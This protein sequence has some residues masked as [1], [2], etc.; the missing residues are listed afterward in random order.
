MTSAAH[1]EYIR[2]KNKSSLIRRWIATIVL[3]SDLESQ[4]MFSCLD[5]VITSGFDTSALTKDNK[6]D[7]PFVRAWLTKELKRCGTGHFDKSDVFAVNTQQIQKAMGL[8][9]VELEVFRFA[10]LLCCYRPLG[11]AAEVGSEGYT[12][13]DVCDLL[14]ELLRKPFDVIYS[15]LR[16]TGLLR[17]SGLVQPSGGGIGNQPLDRWLTIPVMLAREIFR[18]QDEDNL[19]INVFYKTGPK[20]TLKTPDFP[21]RSELSLLKKY[22][23]ASVK[24]G[25]VGANVL[26]WGPPGTGKTEMAR[27]AAQ[28]LRKRSLEISTIDGDNQTLSATD[29]LDC[30]RF[31]QAILARSSNAI[32]TFDEVE[33]V[34]CDGNYSQWGFRAA[35]KFSKSMINTILETNQTPA[36]WITNTVDGID[37]AY[38]R[39]FDFVVNIKSPAA[40]VKKRIA[41]RAFDDLPINKA[42]VDRVVRHDAITPAHLQKVS[43]IC[44]RVGV[45]T[46]YETGHVARQILNGDLR[47]LSELPLG[48]SGTVVK[49]HVALKY[50]PDLINCDTNIEQLTETLRP[51]SSVRI[52]AFGPPGT[53][54]TAW[55]GHLAKKVRRP[56]LVKHAA[57]ILDKYVGGTES[58]VAE[59]FEEAR[60]TRSVLMLDEMDSFL[61]NRANADRHW[62]ITQTNQFLTAM[63]NYNG[64]LICSTNLLEN[65]DPAAMRRFDFKINFDYLK[66]EQACEVALDMLDVLKVEL[67][68]E[69]R[70]QLR[71][72]L[73]GIKLAHGDFA[74]L[75][76]RYVAMRAKPGW[77]Q[78]VG[79]LKVEASFRETENSRPIGF[80]ANV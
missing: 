12:E 6:E 55:A 49:R 19:L 64:I 38:L 4:M 67:S 36:I 43:K 51:G 60:S 56:L 70:G 50:R 61:P 72:G 31:C 42:F 17:Q 28:M 21:Q 62:E 39:R 40:S 1:S 57:D 29:R 45:T 30:Y 68:K 20:S 74:A 48:T 63:E 76:R 53:G 32:V 77:E 22:L 41:Q 25:A 69:D 80:L 79:D 66:P 65:L 59:A 47:A 18:A 14:S 27:H 44:Q 16:P 7:A 15:A 9:S 2:Y 37:P 10:C 33:D 5:R 11:A 8:N 34:L 73:T 23:R 35:G 78:V 24:E 71:I 52:C 75:L 54:K 58:N 3:R 46:A 13:A 26:L